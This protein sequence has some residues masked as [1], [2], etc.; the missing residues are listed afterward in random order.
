MITLN[1]LTFGYKKKLPVLHNLNLILKPGSIYGLLG[2][3]GTGKSSLLY[4]ICG[5]LQPQLGTCEVLGQV[6]SKRDP[7]FLQR[8]FL[9][10]EEIY[11]PD[12]NVAAYLKTYA[13]FY[14]L[15]KTEQF[16]RYL[17]E[18]GL[19]PGGDMQRMSHGEKK[20]VMI[21]FA[22]ATNA[23]VLLMDE[24][25]NGLD[26]PSKKQFRKIIAG[27]IHDDQLMIISTHQV[28]DLD[29]LIDHVLI[30]KDKSIIVDEPVDRITDKLIF[31]QVL[32]LDKV[33]DAIYS[34]SGLKG[35]AVVAP[36]AGKEPSRLD[37]E[38][39]FNA[40]ISQKQQIVELLNS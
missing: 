38:M 26:I 35:Y 27:C 3:N 39:F 32:D 12:I 33:K 19:T 18:F 29:S 8:V 15:F 24:P 37:I 9:L 40:A 5:L 25:T 34:E 7:L 36:N 13:H 11:M 20:K 21:S 16:Y 1:Q 31:R 28:R 23:E 6:P 22:L 30:L 14:P 2:Q 10:P 17:N 4:S